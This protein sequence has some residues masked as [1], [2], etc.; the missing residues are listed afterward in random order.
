MDEGASDVAGWKRGRGRGIWPGPVTREA[1]D[2]ATAEL[3]VLTYMFSQWSVSQGLGGE[4]G[5]RARHGP[6]EGGGS[7]GD[8]EDRGMPG[9]P[10][11][12]ES[13][14]GVVGRFRGVARSA[15]GRS[16][17]SG[18]GCPFF[19][20]HAAP[21]SDHL[22]SPTSPPF[23]QQHP[24]LGPEGAHVVSSLSSVTTE[25]ASAEE[26]IP[27]SVAAKSN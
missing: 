23:G 26:P 21:W 27:S 8:K 19:I 9:L 16:E 20:G 4:G 12:P 18:Y 3:L 15:P 1:S 11:G 2:E 25:I 22:K 17:L 14:D 5:G 6:N 10:N 7:A 24:H 13:E